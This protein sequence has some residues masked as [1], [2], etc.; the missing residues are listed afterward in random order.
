MKLLYSALC[1]TIGGCL[2]FWVKK[3]RFDR[4]NRYGAEEFKSYGNKV[5]STATEKTAWAIA[6]ACIVIGT[7]LAL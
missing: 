3:R 2:A 5:V 6:M 7:L 1:L 4:V